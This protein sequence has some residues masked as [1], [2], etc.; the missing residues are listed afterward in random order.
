[1]PEL[2]EVETVRRGL[3]PVLEGARIVRVEARRPDLRFPFPAKFAQRL[4]GKTIIALGRRAK[5]L[6][7][8]LDGGPVLICHLGMSGSFRIETADDSGTP[9]KF[10]H[11]RS[12]DAKH[13]HVVFH[14]VS[15]AGVQSRVVFNDPRRFGF[16]LFAE[17]LA[18]A[19]PMLAGLGVE[20]TG[21][22]LDGAL[23]ALLLKGRRSPLKAALLDQKLIAGLGNIYVSEAL[24]RAGLSPLR[25]AGTIAGTGKKAKEQSERL[26]EAIR[27]VIADAIAAGGSSLRDYVHTDGSLGYFQHSFAVYDREGEPCPTPGCRGHIGRV[28]QSGRST[29]YCRTCQR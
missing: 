18:D 29:F 20:P 21:N 24:W 14:L 11:E 13:D 15:R 27:S 6:T 7:M 3:Q 5:Y 9:G 26:A 16:M 1:M 12:K 19:H 17:G 8:H 25:E 22:A 23:L 4:T 2:P 28:V 10:H